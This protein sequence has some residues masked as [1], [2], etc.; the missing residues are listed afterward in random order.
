MQRSRTPPPAAVFLGNPD[1]DE[2]GLGDRVLMSQGYSCTWSY[3]AAFGRTYFSAIR[4]GALAPHQRLRRAGRTQ[5]PRAARR[6]SERNAIDLAM[7]GVVFHPELSRPGPPGVTNRESG[8]MERWRG[9]SC[10]MEARRTRT[11]S[12]PSARRAPR[13]E[14]RQLER[15]G[16]RRAIG[17]DSSRVPASNT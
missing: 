7:S 13:A 4:P 2:A 8:L 10:P 5:N 12:G 17:C 1:A 6:V 15:T 14:D 11:R 16:P 3:L 9:I